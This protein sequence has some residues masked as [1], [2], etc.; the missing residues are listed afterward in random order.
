MGNEV[1]VVETC[2]DVLR[3]ERAQGIQETETEKN[4]VATR[5]L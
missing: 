5:D 2:V 3:Q 4:R 1:Q